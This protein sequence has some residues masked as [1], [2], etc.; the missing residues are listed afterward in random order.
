MRGAVL[1]GPRNVRFE[2]R[3]TPAII[4][5]TDAIVRTSATCVCGSDLW[6][7]RGISPVT[8]PTPMLYEQSQ[9]EIQLLQVP[10][11]ERP[12]P[13]LVRRRRVGSLEKD[14]RGAR[15][16]SL[17]ARAVG[18]PERRRGDYQ[19]Q[20]RPRRGA[21]VHPRAKGDAA[22]KAERIRPS[23]AGKRNRRPDS[24]TRP[25]NL[26]AGRC[27]NGPCKT[28]TGARRAAP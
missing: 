22:A 11:S 25:G 15:E 19:T 17:F 5:P 14:V 12:P 10:R 20:R 2:E 24:P 23:V 4:Q 3:R 28:G 21:A 6:P 26:R 13:S 27:S 8:Q 9:Q 18:A 1:Y 16:K 7:Y